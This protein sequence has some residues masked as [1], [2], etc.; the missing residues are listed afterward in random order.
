M[1]KIKYF[2]HCDDS[3]EPHDSD[4]FSVVTFWAHP[5]IPNIRIYVYICMFARTNMAHG[6]GM[7]NNIAGALRRGLFI[8][9]ADTFGPRVRVMRLWRSPMF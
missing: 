3:S 2:V 8:F 4:N 6:P 1:I 7:A 5:I 9:Y